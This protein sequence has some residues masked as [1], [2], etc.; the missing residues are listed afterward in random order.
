MEDWVASEAPVNAGA[1]RS[2]T[3]GLLTGPVSEAEEEKYDDEVESSESEEKGKSKDQSFELRESVVGSFLDDI[4]IGQPQAAESEQP[5]PRRAPS[6]YLRHVTRRERRKS[7]QSGKFPWGKYDRTKLSSP[8]T[9]K[10]GKSSASQ[11]TQSDSSSSENADASNDSNVASFS[12]KRALIK[13]QFGTDLGTNKYHDIREQPDS[14]AFLIEFTDHVGFLNVNSVIDKS[15]EVIGSD[16]EDV[17]S[18]TSNWADVHS[19]KLNYVTDYVN[20]AEFYDEP[21]TLQKHCGSSRFNSY[22]EAQWTRS[23]FILEHDER[24]PGS[25]AFAFFERDSLK[26]SLK[27]HRRLQLSKKSLTE[28]P[29]RNI[30][31]VAEIDVYEVADKSSHDTDSV[32]EIEADNTVNSGERCEVM[33]LAEARDA[34]EDRLLPIKGRD[35]LQLGRNPPGLS[36]FIRTTSKLPMES[37]HGQ[38]EDSQF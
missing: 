25:K 23:H 12:A 36:P 2:E 18:E 9:P 35:D 11:S 38:A 5:T 8:I 13:L 6:L 10:Q 37:R 33:P 17:H 16:L 28:F 19:E 26:R 20:V 4:Y 31:E 1:A 21:A 3:P 24:L 15:V 27:L 32:E 14:K 22:E 34:G 29:E 7:D 30:D